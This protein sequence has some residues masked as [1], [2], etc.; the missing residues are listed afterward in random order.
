MGDGSRLRLTA[1]S[2]KG[3]CPPFVYFNFCFALGWMCMR[4][5]WAMSGRKHGQKSG[6]GLNVGVASSL[7]VS[8]FS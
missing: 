1:I 7:H 3:W 2:V 5:P 6:Q 8:S 4:G